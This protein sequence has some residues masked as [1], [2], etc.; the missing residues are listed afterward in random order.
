MSDYAIHLTASIIGETASALSRTRASLA[1][2]KP[3]LCI[4]D[5]AEPLAKLAAMR[6]KAGCDFLRQRLKSQIQTS[7]R[8]LGKLLVAALPGRKNLSAASSRGPVCALP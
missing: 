6:W 8:N 2:A 7:T 5:R 1:P 3:V 4:L